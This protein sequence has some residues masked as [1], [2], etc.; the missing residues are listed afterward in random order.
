MSKA[1]NTKA[2][3]IE[4]L[5]T[6]ANLVHIGANT[7]TVD[8]LL[9]AMEDVSDELLEDQTSEYLSLNEG[10]V[11][12]LL[13]TG[14]SEMNTKDD[15]TGADK[16]IKVACFTG[17]EN[18]KYIYGGTVVVSALN[19]VQQMPCLVRLSHKGMVKGG[20]GKKYADINVSVLPAAPQS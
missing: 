8:E 12:N 6:E 14:F 15:T 2:A 7:K 10:E 13:F 9:T 3:E 19:R 4:T 5:S 11:K 18:K 1:K 20:N 17:K 16:V